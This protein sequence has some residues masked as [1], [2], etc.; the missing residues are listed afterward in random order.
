MQFEIKYRGKIATT[1]DVEYINQLIKD[2]PKD[3]RFRLSKKI[4]TAWGWRQANG[5]LRDM[6]CR[7]FLLELERHGYIKLPARKQTPPNPFVNRVKPE[8]ISIDTT[9]IYTKVS[10]IQ[11]LMMPGQEDYF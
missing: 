7:G 4:C 6:V 10:D 1:E 5:A 3:G 11:P 8:P 9:P 2:N